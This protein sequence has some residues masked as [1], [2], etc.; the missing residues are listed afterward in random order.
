MTRFKVSLLSIVGLLGCLHCFG[1]QAQNLP[2]AD[3]K[4]NLKQL[5]N[6]S[7]LSSFSD[8]FEAEVWLL[9]MATRI[10]SIYPKT[11]EDE[12]LQ[13]LKSVHHYAR[14][15]KINPQLV[16][17]IIQTE[18]S[19]ERFAI[20]RVGAQGLMQIMPF[21]LKE[22]GHESDNLFHIDTNIRYGCAIFS[23]YLEET[24]GNLT[25]AL[26]RYNGARKSTKYSRKVFNYLRKNWRL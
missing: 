22:I 7:E 15:F 10:R 9:D 26:Q 5:I 25:Q 13:I 17:A 3:F 19:F 4:N 23:L 16:L 24:G 14:Q 12:T 2:S 1:V 11:P 20:S 6:G 18:S 21:W 8:K